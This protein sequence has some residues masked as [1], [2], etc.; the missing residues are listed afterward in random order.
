V[1]WFK[2]N[3]HALNFTNAQDTMMQIINFMMNIWS[4]PHCR[5][6]WNL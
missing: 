3:I 2:I 1:L 4:L 6:Y 5:R